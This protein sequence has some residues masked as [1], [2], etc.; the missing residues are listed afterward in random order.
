MDQNQFEVLVEDY[1]TRPV[2]ESETVG[3]F[4]I[5]LINSSLAMSL[6]GLVTGMEVGTAM[7][8]QWSFWAFVIGGA[9]LAVLGIATGL[10]GCSERLSSYMLIRHVFGEQGSCLINLCFAVS[11]LGWFGVNLNLFS[12]AMGGMTEE[13][14]GFV[15]PP[16]CYILLG[17]LIMIGTSLFGFKALNTLAA[18]AAPVLAVVMVVVVY[19]V[20]TQTTVTA[21]MEVAPSENLSL[22][23]GI[24]AIVGSFVV[25]AVIMP[26]FTRYARRKRDAVI[27]SVVP[28]FMVSSLVYLGAAIA[29][30]LMKESDVLMVLKLMGIGIFAFVLTIA[31]SW[32]ANATIL[33]SC[34][35]SLASIF[36]KVAEWRMVL[37]S[38]VGGALLAFLGILDHFID[39]LLLLSVVFAPVGGICFV[40]YFLTGNRDYGKGS[41]VQRPGVS[42]PAVLA[43]LAGIGAAWLAEQDILSLTGIVSCDSLLVAMILY[44][45]LAKINTKIKLQTTT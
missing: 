4:R 23:E 30:L 12:N 10:V 38:G 32:I 15:M 43:W 5:A 44:L 22:G 18:F 45:G 34:S 37:I 2:P 35:L 7:G 8:L 16:W 36:P 24:S 9:F 21:L 17:S 6:P 3:G 1:A 14:F 25:G 20:L 19:K 40:D 11:L 41:V 27:A 13:L 42:A 31:A 39:F 26:D 29:S 28:F 33:Y